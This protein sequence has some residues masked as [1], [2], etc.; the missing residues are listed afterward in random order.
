[1][2]PNYLHWQYINEGWVG[3]L[4]ATA[5]VLVIISDDVRAATGYDDVLTALKRPS[6]IAAA[7]GGTLCAAAAVAAATPRRPP[8]LR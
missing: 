7:V 6:R 2:F 4:W 8:P 5:A 3:W 1:M